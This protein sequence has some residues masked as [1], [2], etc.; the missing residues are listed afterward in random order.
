MKK[1][2]YFTRAFSLGLLLLVVSCSDIVPDTV[3]KSKDVDLSQFDYLDNLFYE[4]SRENIT[5]VL[6]LEKILVA[7]SEDG[8]LYTFGHQGVKHTATFLFY[9]HDWFMDGDISIEFSGNLDGIDLAFNYITKIF[10]KN[11]G[12]A[13][14]NER[15]DVDATI[16]WIEEDMHGNIYIRK[17]SKYDEMIAANFRIEESDEDYGDGGT[18][19]EWVQRGENGDWVFVPF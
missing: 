16:T 15:T 18:E 1:H 19:G 17:L 14:F 13:D 11:F 8:L 9:G 2:I 4:R 7:D 10:E 3:T 5:K 12:K 6:P